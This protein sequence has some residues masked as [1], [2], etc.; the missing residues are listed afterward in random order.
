VQTE[1]RTT[2]LEHRRCRIA[3]A[4]VERSAQP[5][6]LLGLARLERHGLDAVRLIP[7]NHAAAAVEVTADRS[8]VTLT[9]MPADLTEPGVYN[10]VADGRDPLEDDSHQSDWAEHLERCLAAVL[11]GRY[12]ERLTP[13][14]LEMNFDS[15]FTVYHS[16][17]HNP[18][19][20]EPYGS[21]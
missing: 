7:T 15:P 17:R 11:E 19:H 6:V 4:V 20:Y 12:S 2:E 9:V 5:Y 16:R 21:T 14:G 10:E 8:G 18:H 1:A 13:F 3:F